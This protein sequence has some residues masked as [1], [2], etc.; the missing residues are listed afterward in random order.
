MQ[1][2]MNREGSGCIEILVMQL[3]HCIVGRNFEEVG[4]YPAAIVLAMEE[5]TFMKSSVTD[6]FF[7]NSESWPFGYPDS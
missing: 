3:F 7:F 5:L 4:Y 1:T 6:R 2:N